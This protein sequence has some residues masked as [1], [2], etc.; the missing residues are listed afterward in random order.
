MTP[1][2][3]LGQVCGELGVVFLETTEVSYKC[4]CSRSRVEA[5]LISLGRKELTEIMEDGKPFPVECQFCDT[6]YEFT[7]E[8]VGELLKN[9]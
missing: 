5:A 4:Y 9:I 6:T 2:D 8:Q 3:I 1:E 7:P